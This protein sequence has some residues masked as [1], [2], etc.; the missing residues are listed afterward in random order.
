[1]KAMSFMS[2]LALRLVGL[3]EQAADH[4]LRP[5]IEPVQGCAGDLQHPPVADGE[6]GFVN[7]SMFISFQ[8]CQ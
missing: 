7:E 5:G 6:I 4:D 3:S 8:I 2:P 1:M